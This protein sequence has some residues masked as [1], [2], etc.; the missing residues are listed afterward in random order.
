MIVDTKYYENPRI[1]ERLLPEAIDNNK[2]E[3]IKF[4]TA[5]DTVIKDISY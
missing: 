3:I 1:I 4:L 5:I 2:D